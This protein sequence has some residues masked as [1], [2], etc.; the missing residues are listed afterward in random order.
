MPFNTKLVLILMIKSF[1]AI[2]VQY[3]FEKK[4]DRILKRKKNILPFRLAHDTFTLMH[5]AI[6]QV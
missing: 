3:V 1:A 2:K 5:S 4:N 6:N